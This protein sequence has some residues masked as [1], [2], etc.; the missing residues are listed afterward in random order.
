MSEV[1]FTKFEGDR[2]L[3]WDASSLD[4]FCRCPRY[5]KYNV[6]DGWRGGGNTATDFGSALHSCVEDY[7][8]AL[9]GGAEWKDA[10]RAAVRT[11]VKLG[12]SL[13]SYVPRGAE[14]V[15][16]DDNARTGEALL[17]AIVWYA[18]QY[19][20]DTMSTAVLPDGSAAIEVRF[21]VPIEGTPFRLSGRI[22]KLAWMD[23]GLYI[24]DRKTTATTLGPWY[25]GYYSP[26]TQVDTYIWAV[27]KFLGLPVQGFIVEAFQTAATF[28][29]ISRGI[30]Q[31]TPEQLAEFE[32]DMKAAI[33]QAD[34]NA[35]ANY[36][37]MNRTSCG[38]FG[39]CKFREV[40][41][42]PPRQREEWLSSDYVKRPHPSR[43]E[44][45][46]V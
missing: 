45:T 37:P 27:S 14:K 13:P 38:S 44:V 26:N 17:R 12:A 29:R 22:D 8:K 32:Q 35:A 23:D 31:R 2:Q 36:W 6:L 42:R 4:A 43:K 7:D 15:K 30:M 46:S 1:T 25:F 9:V 3:I 19:R 20:F 28:T 41:A 39:G 40:C 21:E 5:Y 16:G 24:V 11:A 34:L 33:G 10:L 18:D